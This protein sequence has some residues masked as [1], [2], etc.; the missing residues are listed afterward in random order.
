MPRRN[1]SSPKSRS[2]RNLPPEGLNFGKVNSKWN[3]GHLCGVSNAKISSDFA[4]LLIT[5]GDDPVRRVPREKSFDVN[6][7]F[8]FERSVVAV[9]NVPVKCMYRATSPGIEA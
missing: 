2:E 1:T 6:E 4:L 3:Y 8:R 7:N 5:D 9:E